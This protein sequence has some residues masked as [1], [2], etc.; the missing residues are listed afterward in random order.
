MGWMDFMYWNSF[1]NRG[2]THDMED[3]ATMHCSKVKT[4]KICLR[5][6]MN[7]LLMIS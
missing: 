2:Y 6:V 7:E 1:P 3:K 5:W 4:W